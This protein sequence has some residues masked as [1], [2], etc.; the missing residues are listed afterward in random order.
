MKTEDK[1]SSHYIYDIDGAGGGFIFW[2]LIYST[3]NS[4]VIF[5]KHNGL[6]PFMLAFFCGSIVTGLCLAVIGF[7][8]LKRW[9]FSLIVALPISAIG[10]L[11][12]PT[13]TALFGYAIFILWK[14]RHP[15]YPFDKKMKLKEQEI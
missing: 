13:G 7:C 12:F 8:L 4:V 11:G 14:I 10:L 2:G 15:F 3:A 5:A 9:R 1:E 6:E